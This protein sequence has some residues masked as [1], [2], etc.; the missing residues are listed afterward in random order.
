MQLT[1]AILIL[2]LIVGTIAQNCN[3]EAKTCE[4]CMTS[5]CCW[6]DNARCAEND[7]RTHEGN[8]IICGTCSVAAVLTVVFG[9]IGGVCLCCSCIAAIVFYVLYKNS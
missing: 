3:L 5:S 1:F 4:E 9:V 7:G 2:S 6:V 8:T